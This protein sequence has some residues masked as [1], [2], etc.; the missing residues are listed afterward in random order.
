MAKVHYFDATMHILAIN[1]RRSD[2]V[3]EKY[4]AGEKEH[5]GRLWRKPVHKLIG[6][7]I[8]DLGIYFD[9]HMEQVERV[10][11][12]LRG[13]LNDAGPSDEEYWMAVEMAY[14]ILEYGNEDGIPEED[15]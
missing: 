8:T 6:D 9:T 4:K 14:N 7:E 11:E 1:R 2:R 15:R 13:V 10:K 12:L 3:A 5:S